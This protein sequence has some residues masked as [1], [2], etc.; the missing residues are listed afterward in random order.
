MSLLTTTITSIKRYLTNA[1]FKRKNLNIIE[2]I[3]PEHT[4]VILHDLIDQG[5]E[6]AAQFDTPTSLQ[7]QGLCIVRRGQ[8]TLTFTLNQALLGAIVGPARIIEGLANQYGLTSLASP[9]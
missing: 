5:W 3:A 4:A 2:S 1:R 8:S 6:L 7:S 9:S